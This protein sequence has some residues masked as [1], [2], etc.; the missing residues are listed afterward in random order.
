MACVHAVHSSA[1]SSAASLRA[2]Q[3]AVGAAGGLDTV[4]ALAHDA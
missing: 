3:V 2:S 4:S 1:V